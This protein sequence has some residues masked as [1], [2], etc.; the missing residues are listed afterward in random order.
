M[1]EFESPW[2]VPE[3]RIKKCSND[4]AESSRTSIMTAEAIHKLTNT[5]RIV[6]QTGHGFEPGDIIYYNG[7]KYLKAIA[8]ASSTSGRFV[9]NKVT[10]SD[11]FYATAM[12]LAEIDDATFAGTLMAGHY[13]MTSNINAGKAI[14]LDDTAADNYE[15]R[16]IMYQVISVDGSVSVIDVLPWRSDM[17]KPP[18][19]YTLIYTA[20]ANGSISGASPQ[21]VEEGSA[22]ST[23]VANP[24]SGYSFLEWSDGLG[25]ASRTD[26]NVQNDITVEASFGQ[27]AVVTYVAGTGGVITG[28]TP[29]TILLGENGSAVTA[30]PNAGYMFTGWSD[31]NSDETRAE[32]NVTTDVTY[33]ANFALKRTLT[34]NAGDHGI[35]TGV[36]PQ[37]IA[38]GTDGTEV[39]AI[40]DEGWEFTQWSDTNQDNPRTDLNVSSDITVTAE[41]TEAINFVAEGGGDLHQ[42]GRY[43]H[44]YVTPDDRIWMMGQLPY[45]SSVYFFGDTASHYGPVEV[46]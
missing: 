24:A 45:I 40:A 8:T 43:I 34:Y 29:Q 20:G 9:V 6:S 22:G 30:V 39:E 3:H 1:P 17:E 25:G 26:V 31:G 42:S 23:V 37:E 18:E 28:T 32:T 46:T 41:Y 5:T 16:N 35:V 15:L 12:G 27:V 2:D 21:E 33:T 10:G 14:D 4:P 13:Y 36:N 44:V 38:D 19:M 7:A 11:E